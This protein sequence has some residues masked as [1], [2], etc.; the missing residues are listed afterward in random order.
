MFL[1]RV[2]ANTLPTRENLMSRMDITE[3]WY[4]LCNQKVESTSHLFFKCPAT[5]ALWFATCWGFRSEKVHLALSCDIIKLILEPSETF[6]QAHDLWLV[7]L[8]MALT[9]EEIWCIHNAVIH[10]KGPIDL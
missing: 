4:V 9:L 7:S 8:K 5:K 3:P 2:A 10:Q 6:C 1:W